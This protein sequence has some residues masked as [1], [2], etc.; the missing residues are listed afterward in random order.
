MRFQKGRDLITYLVN[1]QDC[2][3]EEQVL[4]GA[5]ADG[6]DHVFGTASDPG[7]LL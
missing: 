6:G 7:N 3:E 2:R 4:T 1:P 5:G